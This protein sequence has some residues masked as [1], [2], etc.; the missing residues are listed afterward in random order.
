MLPAFPTR[1]ALPGALHLYVK[2]LGSRQ[3]FQFSLHRL[4]QSVKLCVVDVRQHEVVRN[5]D[6]S[7]ERFRLAPSCGY[8]CFDHVLYGK[9]DR[10]LAVQVT[11]LVI[12]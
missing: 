11:V 8:G 3:S 5:L 12:R 4:Q 2:K 7:C 6:D 1:R 10:H 9:L